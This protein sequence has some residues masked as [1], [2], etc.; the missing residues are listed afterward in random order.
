MTDLWPFDLPNVHKHGSGLVFEVESLTVEQ[1]K[2]L[3]E[4]QDVEWTIHELA[5][6]AWQVHLRRARTR[7]E[8]SRA[9]A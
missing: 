6:G 7:R 3:T 4:L 8:R 2:R 5:D 9:G 1:A